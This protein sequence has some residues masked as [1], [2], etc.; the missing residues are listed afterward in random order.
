MPQTSEEALARSGASI[1]RGMI[2]LVGRAW[3]GIKATGIVGSGGIGVSQ[4]L[5]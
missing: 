2:V 1:T 4:T 5:R 3:I